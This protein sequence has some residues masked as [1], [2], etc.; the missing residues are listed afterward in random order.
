MAT[1]TGGWNEQP[2]GRHVDTPRPPPLFD[3]FCPDNMSHR[4]PGY[5]TP[6]PLPPLSEDSFSFDPQPARTQESAGAGPLPAQP[7]ATQDNYASAPTATPA[8]TGRPTHS[9][10]AQ[11]ATLQAY[12]P[13][14]FVFTPVPDGGF[15]THD[16]PD[17]EH[18][19]HGMS[20]GRVA[21]IWRENGRTT[22]FLEIYGIRHPSPQRIRTLTD[23]VTA[24]FSAMTHTTGFRVI[25]P[26]AAHPAHRRSSPSTFTLVNV[27]ENIV[28]M[29]VNQRVWSSTLLT[30]LAYRRAITL[31]DFLCRLVNLTQDPELD[32]ARMVWEAFNGPHILPTLLRFA[33]TNPRF[34]GMATEEAANV[35][36]SS[37]RVHITTLDDNRLVAAVYCTSPAATIHEWREWRD[38]VRRAPF[39]SDIQEATVAQLALC[40]GCH[41]AAHPTDLCPYPTL[42]GWNA[43]PLRPRPQAVGNVADLGPSSLT[44]QGDAAGPSNFN[45]NRSQR[46][47]GAP[48]AGRGGG[49]GRQ[50]NGR[51]GANG[52]GNGNNNGG[53]SGYKNG[54]G[55]K[56]GRD[57][58]NGDRYDRYDHDHDSYL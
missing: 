8:P 5:R 58:Y 27:P 28:E 37:L 15:G 52:N 31:P 41:S 38:A 34:N 55:G 25:S 43:P 39:V 18:L 4:P 29:V 3:P 53:G 14:G 23:V 46:G 9:Y 36:L 50:N 57:A 49:G 54:D 13:Q 21:E 26:V 2:S 7:N 51:R 47:R 48:G 10:M 32:V 44:A 42:P 17:P 20:S 11:M 30:I 19:I 45:S 35:V 1:G 12:A 16:F 6:N 56:R 40:A 24:A 33:R 22:L